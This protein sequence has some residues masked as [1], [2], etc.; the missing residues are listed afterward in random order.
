MII[1]DAGHGGKDP[2]A[3]GNGLQEKD[4]SLRI[5]QI[6]KRLCD[7]YKI[8]S[9]IIRNTDMFIDLNARCK[10]INA[11]V[12]N[13]TSDIC[14]SNHVNSADNVTAFGF[15]I[16]KKISDKS[17]YADNLLEIVKRSDILAVRKVYTVQNINGADHFAINRLVKCRSYIL[18]W[19]FIKNKR[20]MDSIKHNIIVMASL[21]IIAYLQEQQR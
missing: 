9:V 14:I 6:Q 21:P 20:D 15:E 12:S 8:K 3:V 5:A 19:G 2:G 4:L 17:S 16:I 11:S 13:T 18:E 10:L 1:I 7:I